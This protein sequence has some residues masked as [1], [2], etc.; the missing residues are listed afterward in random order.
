ML[1]LELGLRFARV[2]FAIQMANGHSVESGI[3]AAL[4]YEKILR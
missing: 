1:L 3:Y 2:R 4:R